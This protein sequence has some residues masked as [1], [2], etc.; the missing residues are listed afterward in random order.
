[1]V[2]VVSL[3]SSIPHDEGLEVLRVAL[4]GREDQ[5]VSTD[6]LVELADLALKND[7]FDFKGSYFQQLR[8]TARG[9]K[10]APS[11]AILFLAALEGKL[12]KEVQY[13]PFLWWRYIDDIVWSGTRGRKTFG[14]H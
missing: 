2:D 7:I 1:M 14:I 5:S 6:T 3:Y 11:Y 12:L 8:G 4:N 10:Y 9:T 13:K